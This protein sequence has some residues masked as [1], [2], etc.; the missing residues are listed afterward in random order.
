MS[1]DRAAARAAHAAIEEALGTIRTAIVQP[2][3]VTECVA[4]ELSRTARRLHEMA[5]AAEAGRNDVR[6]DPSGF[7]A[8]AYYMESWSL[9]IYQTCEYVPI[10]DER[11]GCSECGNTVKLDYDVPVTGETPMPF[12]YCPNCGARVVRTND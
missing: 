4:D 11:F 9:S 10:G 7:H 5:D 1:D 3:G 6:I 12:R 2:V 8:L